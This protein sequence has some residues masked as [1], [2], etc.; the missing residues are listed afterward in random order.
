MLSLPRTLLAPCRRP[1]SISSRR[2]LKEK[3]LLTI[4]ELRMM[5]R[6]KLDFSKSKKMKGKM[7]SRRISSNSLKGLRKLK[8]LKRRFLEQRVSGL[9]IPRLLLIKS[10]LRL[11]LSIMRLLLRPDSLRLRLFKLH[12]L[13]QLKSLLM[14]ML[15]RQQQLPRLKQML[16]LLLLKQSNLKVKLKQRCKNHSR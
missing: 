10:M 9:P 16:L 8:R 5:L 15:I 2:P 1:P 11:I 7:R 6:R 3:G 4:K 14:L 13:M 12:R